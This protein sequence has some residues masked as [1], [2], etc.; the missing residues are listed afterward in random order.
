MTHVIESPQAVPPR[1]PPRRHVRRYLAAG[2]VIAA[3]LLLLPVLAASASTPPTVWGAPPVKHA[4]TFGSNSSPQPTRWG[5]DKTVTTPV[6]K[7]DLSKQASLGIPK[8]HR[9]TKLRYHEVIPAPVRKTIT[10]TSQIHANGVALG[11]SILCTGNYPVGITQ[12]VDGIA[13]YYV[14]QLTVARYQQNV[15]FCWDQTASILNGQPSVFMRESANYGWTFSG[16]F[17]TS[18][19]GSTGFEFN[20]LAPYPYIFHAARMGRFQFVGQGFAFEKTMGLDGYGYWS[21]SWHDGPYFTDQ[22]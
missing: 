6:P 16:E 21:G 2:G 14:F 7:A 1:K 18:C 20:G 17:A 19:C 8:N 12:E 5:M 10:S 9:M 15:Y 13:D 11:D 4:G 3:S 22:L